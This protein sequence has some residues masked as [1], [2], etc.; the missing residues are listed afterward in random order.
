MA[1][2]LKTNVKAY[3]RMENLSPDKCALSR[4]ATAKLLICN[5]IFQNKTIGLRG[6]KEKYYLKH[7][8]MLCLRF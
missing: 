4:I 6:F 1:L 7:A 5:V 3:L 2:Y 8:V